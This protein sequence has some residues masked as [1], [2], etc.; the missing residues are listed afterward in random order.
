MEIFVYFASRYE[1]KNLITYSMK[2]MTP[3]RGFIISDQVVVFHIS[4]QSKQNIS[5]PYN[6]GLKIVNNKTIWY[7]TTSFSSLSVTSKM[8]SMSSCLPA[9]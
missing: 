5:I 6:L 2:P 1:M 3:L 7:V 9:K 4:M 8:T